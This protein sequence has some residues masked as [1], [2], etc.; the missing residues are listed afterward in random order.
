MYHSAGGP[1]R[2]IRQTPLILMRLGGVGKVEGDRALLIAQMEYSLVVSSEP[3]SAITFAATDESLDDLGLYCLNLR[4]RNDR[5]ETLVFARIA[6]A[7]QPRK[8][9][10]SP[11]G[12]TQRMSFIYLRNSSF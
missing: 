7:D 6:L 1:L 9:T 12:E 5:R 4:G 2:I 3:A 11:A 10:V 8:F